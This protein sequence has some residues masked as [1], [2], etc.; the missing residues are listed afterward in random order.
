MK[1]HSGASRAEIRL[2]GKG[3]VISL[4]LSDEGVGVPL[5]RVSAGLGVRSMQERLRLLN[6]RFEIRSQPGV[7]TVIQATVPLPPK[8]FT[9]V[10]TERDRSTRR[11]VYAT[12]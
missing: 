12:D 4:S 6:G 1:R 10:H 2:E 5:S 9:S 8:E 11:D 3:E 7:G